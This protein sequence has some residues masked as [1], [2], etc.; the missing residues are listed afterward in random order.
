MALLRAG[1]YIAMALLAL[2]SW[3][4]DDLRGRYKDLADA[5][6]LTIESMDRQ[7]KTKDKEWRAKEAR[8]AED[9]KLIVKGRN[10]EIEKLAAARDAALAELRNRPRRP[11]PG[12]ANN[13]SAGQGAAPGCT[14]SQ[15]YRDDAE[16]LIGEAARADAIVIELKSCYAQYDSLLK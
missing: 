4:L 7:A 8:W 2:W 5:R 6:Q 14:G 13:S 15:L 1:P 12:A 3:R 11:S 16:F 9:Q 10:D